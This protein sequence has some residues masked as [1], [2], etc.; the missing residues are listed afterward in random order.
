MT[1]LRSNNRKIVSISKLGEFAKDIESAYDEEGINIS[2]QSGIAEIICAGK[3]LALASPSNPALEGDFLLGLHLERIHKAVAPL[4]DHPR[5]AEY[6]K[7]L[8]SGNLRFLNRVQ[9]DAR[10]FLF[11]LEVWRS[12]NECKPGCAELDEPDVFLKLNNQRVGVACKKIYS[13][14]GVSKTLS[15][16]VKQLRRESP[17]YGIVAFSIDDLFPDGEAVSGETFDDVS[18]FLSIQCRIF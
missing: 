11:E 4:K 14:R 18:D 13:E 2:P 16:A 7:H 9:S 3:K 5:K 8:K 1:D 10:N 15:N 6:L 17:G 12:L